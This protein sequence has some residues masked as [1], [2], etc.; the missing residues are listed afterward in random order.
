MRRLSSLISRQTPAQPARGRRSREEEIVSFK[1][2]PKRSLN[3]GG[4]K[5]YR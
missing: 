2:R 5:L 4:H 1:P 3:E